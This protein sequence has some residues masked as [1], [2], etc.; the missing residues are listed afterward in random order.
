MN[1]ECLINIVFI[2]FLVL[3]GIIAYLMLR[4]GHIIGGD[5]SLYIRQAKCIVEGD[6]QLVAED[7]KFM[8]ANSSDDKFSPVLYPWGF[9][10]LLSPVYMALGMDF[11]CFKF[12]ILL[13]YICAIVLIYLLFRRKE[14]FRWQAFLI[15]A[16]IGIQPKY[17][18]Y[19]NL[20]LSEIPY[21]FFVV[22]SIY[23]LNRVYI[24][25]YPEKSR[26]LIYAGVGVLLMFT[27]QIRTEGILLLFAFGMW[28]LYYFFQ[29][30]TYLKADKNRMLSFLLAGI[31]PCFT[32][33]SFFLLLSVCLPSGFMKHT[34]HFEL[35]TVERIIS[36][37]Q[38]YFY[39]FTSFPPLNSDLK[40]AIF[41]LLVLWGMLFRFRV[42]FLEVVFVLLS[43]FLFIIWPHQNTRH[44]F[45]LLPFLLYFFVR[46]LE[47]IIQ[48]K[49]AEKLSVVFLCICFILVLP[50]SVKAGIWAYNSEERKIP[51]GV[52]SRNAQ[53]L[54]DYVNKS[55]PSCDVI[56][57]AHSRLL[58]LQTGRKVVA[59]W[60]SIRQ[61]C[62]VADWYI[63]CIGGGDYFQ[64]TES[65]IE[66]SKSL[67]NERFRNSSYIVYK[68][69]RNGR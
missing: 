55:V 3:I 50:L 40:I 49:H 14:D 57:F 43:L 51:Y 65:E 4:P 26:L 46:G 12:Y 38:G 10:L 22:L 7:M 63:Y 36:N 60:G 53:E 58:C 44:L 52:E 1:K 66:Y 6:A 2:L 69:N 62:V 30:K 5:Y 48:K 9:P 28:W 41:L 35:M 19:L 23:V 47:A 64:Y 34:E 17:L 8:L 25:K 21:L 27:A 59:L 42:D 15:A 67:F 37:L 20:V 16:L 33:I 11:Y 32:A 31:I 18:S 68:I 61:T 39:S 24:G 13:F 56:A 29:N 54:F 45:T